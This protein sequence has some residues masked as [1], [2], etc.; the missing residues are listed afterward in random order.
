MPLSNEVPLEDALQIAAGYHRQNNLVLADRTYRDILK[1]A[2]DHFDALHNLAIICYQRGRLDEAARVITHAYEAGGRESTAPRFW[3]N[4]A[5]MMAE[6]GS[7]DKALSGWERAIELDPT[8][9]DALSSKANALW[10]L[11]RYEEAE[12]LCRRAL[13]IQPAMLD[14]QLNLGNALVAQGKREDALAVWQEI[15]R[16]HPTFANAWNNI[17]NALR[18]GG[19]LTEAEAACRKALEIDPKLVFAMNNLGNVLRD[20][21]KS[22]EAEDWFRKAVSLKPDYAEAQNNLGVALL[23]QQRYEEAAT[24]IRYAIAFK[25][26]YGD[27][28]GNLCLALMELGEIEDAQEHAQKAI[29]LKPA[30][31]QAYAELSDVLFAADR[32]DEAEAALEDA[33]QL[34]PDSPRFYL[35]LATVLERANRI[36]DA[37]AAIDKA[38]A[39]NPEMPEAYLRKGVTYFLSNR[40]PEAISAVNQALALKPDLAMGYATLAEIQQ[41]EGN[42]EASIEYVRQGLAVSRDL[43]S[44][45]YSL[46]KARKYKADS[47]DFHDLCALENG[48]EKRGSQYCISLYFAL[49]NAYEDIGDYKKSFTYLKKGN[50]AK[51]RTISYNHELAA[52]GF[53]QIRETYSRATIDQF[54]GKGCVSDL[55]V[56]IVGMPRSGTTLT[57]QI[58]SSHPDV[59]GAGELMDLTA[60]ERT[61]GA[62]TTDNA[63]AFG[64]TYV[65]MIRARDPS[66]KAL[67]ITDKMPGNYSRI[68]EIICTL[69]HAKIIHCRRDPID[70]CLSCYKQL[71]ARGQYWSYNLEELAAQY[72]LYEELMD[73]WRQIVPERFIE[74]EYEDTVNNL[75]AV[76]RRLIDYVGLPWDEACLK[77][78]EQKRTVLTASKMQVIK[79]VYTTSVKSWK[80]YEDELQPLIRA[81]DYKEA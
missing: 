29:L 39:L 10:A 6:T 44:L 71:F 81:L 20:Q 63:A 61:S 78:H 80:R 1:A 33:L 11:G 24:A 68:G 35:K 8:F 59:F 38:V 26:E 9:V 40:V 53:K 21:G 58:I 41:S 15:T 14:A 47:E 52:E 57:E 36:D 31:A 2:P 72:K 34:E 69:P 51:R 37:L 50:D 25:P 42:I 17:G 56:F 45:F 49:A 5:V 54:A 7:A 64:Q 74:V 48:A 32:I 22:K 66:G 46:G 77:P 67:R 75:E 19:K 73:H 27:A 43:P 18:D 79:P 16:I 55:P 23:D 28:H 60:T 76:A 3:N 70:T 12:T 62:L 65:D 13:A 4:Y 30:S